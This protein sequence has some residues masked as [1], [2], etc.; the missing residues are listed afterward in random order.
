VVGFDAMDTDL[1]L[2]LVAEGRMPAL[3]AVLDAAAWTRTTTPPGLVV[4]A[5]WP[6]ITTGCSPDRHGFYAD[7]QQG[8][9]TYEARPSGPWIVQQPRVWETL[10]AAGRDR[11]VLDVPLTMPARELRGVQLVEWGSHDRFVMPTASVPS[12][13]AGEVEDRFGEYPVQPKCD[14][15]ADDLPALYDALFR[16]VEL[17]R[18][19]ARH[20]LEHHVADF[21]MFV[22]SESHCAGHHFWRIHD[23]DHAL[24]DPE[25][26]A[27]LGDVVELVYEALDDALGRILE[28]VPDDASVAIV[29]S[30]GMGAH[31]D[32]NHLLRKVCRT[33]DARD[34]PSPVRDLRERALRR[35]TRKRRAARHA[36][37]LDGSRRYFWVPNNDLYGAIRI[38]LRGREPRG[39]VAPGAEADALAEE[40]RA[41]LLALENAETGAPAVADVVRISDLYDGP[42]RDVLPDLI[43]EWNRSAVIRGLRSE[44]LGEVW[45]TPTPLRSGDHRPGGLFALTAAGLAPGCRAGTMPVENIAPTLA[46]QLGVE[47]TGTDG[48]RWDAASDDPSSDRATV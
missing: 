11:V 28:R 15:Y 32:G 9:G 37:S 36:Y 22:F 17:H 6:T 42:R 48:R 21:N 4:G 45:H 19:L 7:F 44:K 23:P 29:C 33:L 38:N 26:R 34:A 24:H 2:G 18:D 39:C 12:E 16:G 40:I 20:H 47:L 25:L 31:Y 30:H 35:F 27:Q 46:A 5:V 3:A 1:A 14:D 10:S 43:V 13:F 8:P 41:D